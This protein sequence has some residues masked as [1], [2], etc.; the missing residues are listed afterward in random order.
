MRSSNLPGVPVFTGLNGL[1]DRASR[2][3]VGRPDEVPQRRT[4]QS[5][6]ENPLFVDND[7]SGVGSVGGVGELLQELDQAALD[8]MPWYRPDLDSKKR[9]RALLAGTAQGMFCVRPS[10]TQPGCFALSI[11]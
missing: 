8:S 9:A 4:S 7:V 1:R 6:T 2:K 11:A 3:L 10:A 5:P